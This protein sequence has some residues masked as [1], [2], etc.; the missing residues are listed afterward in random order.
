MPLEILLKIYPNLLINLRKT[1]K[2]NE[3]LI[4]M[5]TK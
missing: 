3:K 2:T 1:R 4:K 5:D